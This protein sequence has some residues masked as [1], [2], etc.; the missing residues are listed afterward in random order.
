MFFQLFLV[1]PLIALAW[2][3]SSVIAFTMHEFNHALIA[4][5]LGDKTAKE[6]G[7]LTLNPLAH[8]DP[9]G[10]LM[11]LMVGFGWAKPVPFLASNFKRPVLGSALVGLAG[12]SVNLLIAF[13]STFLF[14][15]F[16]NHLASDFFSAFF[17]FLTLINLFLVIFNIVPLPPLDGSKLL[18]GFLQNAK[19]NFFREYITLRGPQIL[20][21][22]SVISLLTPW[23]PFL[24]VSKSAFFVC[25]RISGF[26]C[27]AFLSQIENGG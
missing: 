25:D 13:T 7:R 6:A 20:L 26:S 19:F 23:N 24:P 14:Y 15:T 11:L 21:F 5:L 10:F 2:L 27:D 4:N 18:F 16:S 8:I 9:I 1:N 17:F 12:P 22:L 3:L